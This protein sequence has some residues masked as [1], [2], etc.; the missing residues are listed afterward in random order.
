MAKNII[1]LFD[2]D[3]TLIDST[4]AIVDSF[5]TAYICHDQAPPSREAIVKLI[6]YPLAQM[7]AQL[8]VNGAI[9][10][11]VARYK[12]KYREI[13]TAQ[14]TLLPR[15]N[16]A[17][18]LLYPIAKIAVVTTKTA[19]FSRVLLEHLGAAKYIDAIVGY[20]DVKNPKPHAEPILLALERLGH[21]AK[22]PIAAEQT[23]MI[24]DTGF[25]IEAAL[26]AKI[27]PI[28]LLCG[29]STR[30]ELSQFECEICTDA[31]DAAKMIV[32]RFCP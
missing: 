15:A 14:T 19:S 8:G 3:G 4:Q 30:E 20:E 12:E 2:L 7:F 17:L 16:D 13:C 27:T 31:F 28:A 21:G 5:E 9:D 25:D 32:N 26:N 29:Y 1:A 10:S 24:G 18:A 23:F 11:F 6:G 22:N